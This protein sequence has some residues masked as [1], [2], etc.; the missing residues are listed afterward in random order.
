M[1]GPDKIFGGDVADFH[2]VPGF[3][4]GVIGG[5]PCQDFTRARRS[6]P[7]GYGLKM[8]EHYVRVVREADP[9][10][11][12]LENV[13]GCP[14]VEIPGYI[15]QRFFLNAAECGGRQHRNRFFQ[16]GSKDGTPM[17]P[18]RLPRAA[19][20]LRTCMA[21]E[22][23]QKSR[24]NWADFCELQGLPRDFD[25][26]GWSTSAKYRAVGNGVPVYMARILA[27]AIR[28]RSA[29]IG[30]SLCACQCGRIVTGRQIM[31]TPACRKRMERSRRDAKIAGSAG[32]VTAIAASAGSGAGGP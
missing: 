31:A 19:V 7:T 21:I 24:R 26:P 2:P 12:L 8:L 17:V 32:G 28:D 22:G 18:R 29:T 14:V 13:P 16:F 11:F 20:T 30:V 3:A 5:P 9:A 25:L 10:W 23:S 1:R 6:A 27:E 4:A 15:M